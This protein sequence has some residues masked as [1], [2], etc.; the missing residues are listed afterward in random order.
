M[1]SPALTRRNNTVS[2]P[3]ESPRRGHAGRTRV[4]A[5]PR[6]RWGN[7]EAAELTTGLFGSAGGKADVG[8]GEQ[9]AQAA[10]APSGDSRAHDP[11]LRVVAKEL[12]CIMSEGCADQDASILGEA[13]ASDAADVDVLVP[14]QGFAS[15]MLSAVRKATV[16]V[17]PLASQLWRAI[18]PPSRAAI[19]G[20]NQTNAAGDGGL[21]RLGFG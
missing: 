13:D 19:R 11:E 1:T 6:Y 10:D 4:Q 2:R 9:S 21:S 17:G 16:M 8:S 12:G 20:I 18:Q 14:D 5:G 15:S 7:L 3:E